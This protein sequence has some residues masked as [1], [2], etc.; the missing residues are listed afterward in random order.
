LLVID[1]LEVGGAERHVTDLAHALQDVG[2]V[3]A[4]ACASGGAL[5]TELQSAGIPVHVLM[6]GDVKHRV[7]CSFAW[8]LRKVVLNAGYDLVHAHLYASAVAA[9]VATIG[10]RSAL[11]IT[12]HSEGSWEGVF[13]RRVSGLAYHRADGLIA[14]SHPIARQLRGRYHVAGDRVSVIANALYQPVPISGIAGS[15]RTQGG[16]VVGVVSRLRREKGVDIFLDAVSGLV[17]RHPEIGCIVVGD[18]PLLDRL[19]RQARDLGLDSHVQFLGCRP[20]ARRLIPSFDVL[21]VP[22][23]TEGSP[24]AVLEAMAAGVAVIAADVGGV[25]DQIRHGVD[26]LLVAPDNP[27]ELEDAID[28]LLT[29][30]VLREQLGREGRRHIALCFPY[31]AVLESVERVYRAA[32]AARQARTRLPSEPSWE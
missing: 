27:Q 10:T 28:M 25:S 6:A 8:R 31:A 2:H 9:S 3:V 32:L 12:V 1:S 26:G 16:E 18:G 21:V 23:R 24:L 5:L 14:V 22:S 29:S 15:S 13:A 17:P 4:V 7:K 19:Q 11:I 30:T 20:D